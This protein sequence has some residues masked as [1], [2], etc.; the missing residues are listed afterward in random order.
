M[1][2]NLLVILLTMTD[3]S[4]CPMPDSFKNSELVTYANE[5][6]KKVL[7][8]NSLKIMFPKL[9]FPDDIDCSQALWNIVQTI[10]V[11][12]YDILCLSVENDE[13][14]KIFEEMKLSN[15]LMCLFYPEF[16]DMENVDW[17]HAEVNNKFYDNYHK[18][19]KIFVKEYPIWFSR[20]KLTKRANA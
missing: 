20:G 16:S 14:L 3:Q 15:D 10:T 8:P 5:H 11:D 19:M 4:S 2:N 13:Y 7:N 17:L 9:S 12:D 1:K 18:I 6:F